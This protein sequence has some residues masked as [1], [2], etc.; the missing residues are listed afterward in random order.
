MALREKIK[1]ALQG[2]AK[3]VAIGGA[4]SLGAEGASALVRH[5][6]GSP[7]MQDSKRIEFTD[8]GPSVIRMDSVETAPKSKW[9]LSMITWML[10]TAGVCLCLCIPFLRALNVLNHHCNVRRVFRIKSPLCP[11]VNKND[12]AS[13]VEDQDDPPAISMEDYWR[14]MDEVKHEVE[15]EL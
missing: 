4:L 2:G 9:P 6:E 1:K 13:P 11:P 15:E 8:W 14:S 10:I 5:A 7:N 12:T 3:Y